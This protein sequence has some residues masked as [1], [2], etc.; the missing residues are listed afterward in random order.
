MEYFKTAS[1]F[2]ELFSVEPDRGGA[3]DFR[4][5]AEL[6][7]LMMH[8]H[9]HG[10]TVA[11]LARRMMQQAG[12][13]PKV[14]W[15]RMKT[16]LSPIFKEDPA[17]LRAMGLPVGGGLK[18]TCPYLAECVALTIEPSVPHTPETAAMA[19]AVAREVKENGKA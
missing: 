9:S 11:M 4:D 18:L 5:L 6:L 15:S 1:E 16:A 13:S 12:M 10:V 7:A 8:Y 2:L 3:A 17:T 19:E 14:Y